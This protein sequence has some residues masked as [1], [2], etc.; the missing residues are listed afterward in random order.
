MRQG[1][2]LPILQKMCGTIDK[3]LPMSAQLETLEP[4]GNDSAIFAMQFIAVGSK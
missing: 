2:K 4:E 1:P 3:L